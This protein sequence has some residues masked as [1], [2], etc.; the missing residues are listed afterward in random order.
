MQWPGVAFSLHNRE[1]EAGRS[2]GSQ[3]QPGLHR[4]LPDSQEY[5]ETLS[6]KE[7]N[8][9]KKILRNYFLKKAEREGGGES[10]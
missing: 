4:G 6:Q 10:G 2:L 7:L 8:N 1:A 3:D 5:R 9:I